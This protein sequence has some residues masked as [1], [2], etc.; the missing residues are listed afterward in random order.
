VQFRYMLEGNDQAWL[1]AGARRQAFYTNL[2]PAT[3]RFRVAARLGDGE[4]VEAGRPWEFSVAPA[5]YQTPWFYLIGAAGVAVV[6]W[7]AWRYRLRM[8]KREYQLVI[9]ERA[10]LAREIHDTLLQGMAGVA[11]QLHGVLQ[12]PGGVSG[13]ARAR[14]DRT[15]TDTHFFS[16]HP[17]ASSFP[18]STRPIPMAGRPRVGWRGRTST[19]FGR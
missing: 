12:A 10:R 19:I 17:S 6:G 2:A 8:V 1:Y 3:Y 13:A 4:W 11:L 9:A 5:F 7:S 15:W 18:R 16:R 14:C